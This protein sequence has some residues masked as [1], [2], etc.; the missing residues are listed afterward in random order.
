MDTTPVTAPMYGVVVS[1]DVIPG[2]SVPAGAPL[3]VLESMKM[4]HVVV[5]P[6]G[7]VV[8]DVAA[9]TGEVVR[10]DEL[11]LS[12]EEGEV[13]PPAEPEDVA[14]RE[15]ADLAEVLRR[16]EIGLDAARPG[17]RPAPA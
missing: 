8:R 17:R 7:G 6:V 10:E 3:L 12:M 13:A 15:R 16:H 11:L 2:Q 5:A 14:P 4:E 1:I 9:V